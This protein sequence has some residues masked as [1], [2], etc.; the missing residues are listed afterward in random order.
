MSEERN[1]GVQ[2]IAMLL[3][4]LELKHNDLVQASDEQLTHKM[5]AR[6]VKGRRLTQNTKGKIIRALNKASS[7]EFQMSELF[8]Y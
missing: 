8:N 1:L 3:E 4:Q 5:V 6:A 7:R 2:P